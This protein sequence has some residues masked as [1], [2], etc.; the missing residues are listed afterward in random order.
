MIIIIILNKLTYHPFPMRNLVWSKSQTPQ[1]TSSINSMASSVQ[2][3]AFEIA[4]AHYKGQY[5]IVA[6]NLGNSWIYEK[7]HYG[8]HNENPLYGCI[9]L[10]CKSIYHG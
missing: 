1:K 10:L 4:T 3:R 5:C 8:F 2:I 6:L 9:F 7:Q